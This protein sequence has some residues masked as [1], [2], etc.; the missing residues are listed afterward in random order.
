MPAD[1]PFLF[2]SWDACL[3]H[4]G[5]W[6]ADLSL[7]QLRTAKANELIFRQDAP[8]RYFYLIR[9]GFV[10]C[11]MLHDSGQR[12]MLELMGPGSMFGEGAAFDGHTRYVDAWAAT[13]VQLSAYT[14]EEIRNAGERAPAFLE[15]L[16]KIMATKQRI[17]ASKLLLFN[18]EDPEGRLRPLLA[19]LV[20]VQQRAN[21]ADA[22]RARQIW[23]SQ[24]RLAEMCG[25][26]RISAA[27]ALKRLSDLG[28][29]RTH[30]RYV[31]V[32]NPTGLETR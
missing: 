7:G 20:A 1:S 28:L 5:P 9:E 29:I 3:E 24:E 13:D 4:T 11:A 19:R 22:E 2:A 16:I 26:S 14:A 21:P 8:H 23:H 18:S 17:L 25:M 27:R 30:L 6:L 31:E 15:S 32:L 10:Q 12:L